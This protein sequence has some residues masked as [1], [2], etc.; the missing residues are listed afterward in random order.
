MRNLAT[1]TLALLLVVPACADDGSTATTSSAPPTSS[2]A[3]VIESAPVR[4]PIDAVTLQAEAD[5]LTRVVDGHIA[6]WQAQDADLIRS[7][8]GPDTIHEDTGFG[9]LLSGDE[10]FAMPDGFFLNIPDF[11]WEITEILVSTGVALEVSNGWNVQLKAYAFT[12]E[13]PLHEIDRYEV[14]AT[15][16]LGRWTLLYGLDTYELWQASPSRMA[17]AYD[18]LDAYAAAWQSG[19]QDQIAA[20]YA[21]DAVRLDSVFGLELTGVG[22]I[23][24]HAADFVAWYPNSS[25]T[26]RMGFSSN[27][28]SARQP[29]RI[30]SLFDIDVDDCT[31]TT[32]SILTVLDGLIVNDEVF[33]DATSLVDCGWA[34]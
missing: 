23:Q 8:W 3:P 31:V 28:L 19:D 30:G 18:L 15:G 6:A 32:A 1:F 2:T 22:E 14:D 26:Q 7:F 17:V 4:P 13:V 10:L 5:R 33:W 25:L 11:A 24:A 29:E 9:V 27:R 12:Q 21:P 16:T 20:L 34:A